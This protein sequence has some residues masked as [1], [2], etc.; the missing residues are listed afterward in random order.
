LDT[1]T[2]DM[3]SVL[4]LLHSSGW[5]SAAPAAPAAAP[6]PGAN[7]GKSIGCTLYK[8]HARA[9]AHMSANHDVRQIMELLHRPAIG[10]SPS[11]SLPSLAIQ[12]NGAGPWAHCC[13]R[14]L[15]DSLTPSHRAPRPNTTVPDLVMLLSLHAMPCH[16]LDCPWQAR[17]EPFRFR[18]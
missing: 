8:R 7:Y 15:L 10:K 17:N 6:A 9:R 5:H 16:T 14:S 18:R 1:P 11:R 12:V 4:H 13:S 3:P 2:V